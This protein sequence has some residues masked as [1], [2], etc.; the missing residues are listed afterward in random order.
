MRAHCECCG[1]PGGECCERTGICCEPPPG[2]P[3][4]AAT[5]APLFPPLWFTPPGMAKA[6][7]AP[8]TQSLVLI[9]GC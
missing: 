6:I 1:A 5:S 8:T 9:T 7:P 4:G 2:E 3:E